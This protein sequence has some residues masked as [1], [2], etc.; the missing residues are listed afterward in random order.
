MF[1]RKPY[2]GPRKLVLAFDVGTTYSGISY[3]ILQPGQIPEIRGVTKFPGQADGRGNAKVPSILYY[4]TS[5]NVKA[6]GS[7][8]LRRN[9][10]EEAEENGWAKA[11]WWKLHLRPKHLASAHIKDND[12]PPLPPGKSAVDILTDLIKY[13]YTNAKTYIQQ[14]HM[15]LHWKSIENSIEFVFSHPNGWEGLQQQKYREAIEGAGLIPCTPEGRSRVHMITEGEASLH[16]CVSSLPEELDD[17][18]P[19]AI[20]IIDAGGG[21]ID[22][23]VYSLTF[24]PIVCKEIAPAECRLQGSVFVTRR[25]ANLLLRKLKGSRHSSTEEMDDLTREFDE[26]TK[27]TISNVDEPVYLTMGNIRYNNPKFNIK[28]GALVLS[29]E[30]ATDLFEESIKAIIDA[31]DRQR[32]AANT[33]ITMA[34]LVGG[35]GTNDFVWTRLQ[36]HF[37]SQG[38]KVCRPDN[39]INK[40]V[41]NGAVIFHIH[42]A[43]KSR[44]ARY[45]YGAPFS[46]WVDESNPEHNRR[47]KHWRKSPC[48]RY[49]VDGGFFPILRK[50]EQVDEEKEIRHTFCFINKHQAE[51][52][53]EQMMIVCYR[54]N[55]SNPGWLDEDIS[56]F[57]ELRTVAKANL[58]G[59]AYNSAAKIGISG[60]AYYQVDVDLV[61]YFGSTELTAQMEWEDNGVKHCSPASIGYYDS[62]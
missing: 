20:V 46:P 52:G 40:A 17:S 53:G 57:T 1:T 59:A 26:S 9:V 6:V 37:G 60:E 35:L 41:A 34:F 62:D 8:A 11:E 18:G 22:L 24:N 33:N 36:A 56:S 14:H 7:E 5:G 21:T 12:I 29:G 48:G 47:K 49:L 39:D 15:G 31:F 38:I 45:T 51:F 25:A 43:V 19:Q 44:V 10:I 50:G 55:L 13:L 32:K 61:V 42:P 30:E 16:Y 28:R 2:S 3:S 23:S 54:G 27:L 58:S 4:D